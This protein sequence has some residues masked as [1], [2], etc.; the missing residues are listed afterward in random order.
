[1]GDIEKIKDRHILHIKLIIILACSVVA[2][3]SGTMG[4]ISGYMALDTIGAVADGLN[5]GADKVEKLVKAINGINEVQ[6]K[7][8]EYYYTLE[9]IGFAIM[10]IGF[11]SVTVIDLIWLMKKYRKYR[12]EK[13]AE[14]CSATSET[15]ENND[16]N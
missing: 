7:Y 1:M 13:A 10:M 4:W 5:Q 15:E 16:K 8:M 6:T 11:M 14:E 9:K 3:L 12:R 2:F